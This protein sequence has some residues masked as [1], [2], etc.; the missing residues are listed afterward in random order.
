MSQ[1]EDQI[2]NGFQNEHFDDETAS[3]FLVC[4]LIFKKEYIF[5]IY[6][7]SSGLLS[8]AVNLK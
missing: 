6:Y 4:V 1:D 2:K 3:T 5:M 8:T 7:Y